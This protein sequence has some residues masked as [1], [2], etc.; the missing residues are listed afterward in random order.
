MLRVLL[1]VWAEGLQVDPVLDHGNPVG[2]HDGAVDDIGALSGD[3]GLALLQLGDEPL[4]LPL[5]P[6]S[7]GD[8]GRVIYGTTDLCSDGSLSVPPNFA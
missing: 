8:L 3:K 4:A 7:L 1:L 6:P 5:G 2:Q